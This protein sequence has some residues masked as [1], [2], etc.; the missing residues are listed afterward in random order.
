MPTHGASSP[1]NARALLFDRA[2]ARRGSKDAATKS[3][4]RSAP[5]EVGAMQARLSRAPASSVVIDRGRSSLTTFVFCSS[6]WDSSA[7]CWRMCLYPSA[8]TRSAFVAVAVLLLLVSSPLV[9][10]SVLTDVAGYTVAWLVLPLV[11]F[12][13]VRVQPLNSTQKKFNVFGYRRDATGIIEIDCTVAC[14][15]GFIIVLIGIL[16]ISQLI[17]AFA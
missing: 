4:L 1:Q 10:F 6:N 17:Q 2:R 7:S 3:K 8:V 16:M 14:F 12:G 15:I 5:T 13:R 11:S 9:I